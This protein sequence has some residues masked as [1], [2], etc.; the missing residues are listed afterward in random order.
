MAE[1]FQRPKTYQQ[2]AEFF[3]MEQRET[4]NILLLKKII[5]SK[6]FLGRGDEVM[7]VQVKRVSIGQSSYI[8]SQ[9]MLSPESG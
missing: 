4:A 2:H 1:A 6:E 5:Y 7:A 8:K 3:F 9:L